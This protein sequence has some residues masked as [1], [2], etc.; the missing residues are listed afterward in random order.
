MS[1]RALCGAVIYAKDLARMT[2]YYREL[3]QAQALSSG[4]DHAILQAQGIELV[5]HAIPTHIA[6]DIEIASPPTPR[7]EQAIKL[8][9]TVPQLSQ[10]IETVIAHGG[11]LCGRAWRGGGFRAQDATDPEGNVL[12]L[13][14]T[15]VM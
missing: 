10:A 9:F 13:R 8:S 7:E 1:N 3:L 14:Q 4:I 15:E 11:V 12:Q 6:E 2:R 5:I